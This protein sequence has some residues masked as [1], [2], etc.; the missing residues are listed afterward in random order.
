MKTQEAITGGRRG[1]GRPA[2][3]TDY[4]SA[5]VR[6]ARHQFGE[7]G[8]RATTLR[9]VAHDAGVDPR[10]VLH[11]FGSK[12]HLFVSSVELPIEPELVLARVFGGGAADVAP[13]VV[14]VILDVLEDAA[15]RDAFLA[16]MRAAV[17]EPEAAELIRSLFSERLLMPIASRFGGKQPSLRAS[18]IA[19][20]LVGLAIV[21]YVV[22]VDPLAHAGREQLVRA[23]VP[24][25]RHYLED[26]WV[27]SA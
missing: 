4:R 10:L 2:G 25:I 16:L 24:V 6:A 23:L 1:R 22:Q 15:R 27:I 9:S 5:I 19:T 17:T 11:Y 18:M 12:Q 8:Y 13:R 26:D 20:Q 21:R 3:E 7:R 14:D